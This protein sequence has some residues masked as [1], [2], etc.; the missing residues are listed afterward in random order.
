MEIIILKQISYTRGKEHIL[1][2][3]KQIGKKIES[4]ADLSFL[5]STRASTIISF[6]FINII[7][8]IHIEDN[9]TFIDIINL[10]RQLVGRSKNEFKKSERP[11]LIWNMINEIKPEEIGFDAIKLKEKIESAKAVF[12]GVVPNDFNA[13]TIYSFLLDCIEI[14]YVNLKKELSISNEKER[15]IQIEVKLNN[16]L[17]TAQKSGIN[18]D[19]QKVKQYIQE[20]NIDL[21]AVKNKLQLKFGVFSMYDYDNIRTKLITDFPWFKDIKLNSKEFWKAIKLQRNNSEFIELLYLERKHTKNKTILTR[22]GSLDIDNV[23]PMLDY[24]GTITGRI[25]ADSPSLQQLNKVYRDIIIPRAEMELVYIDYCQFEAGILAFEADEG[26]LIEMYNK[27]DI[28]TEISNKLGTKNVSRD[29]AKKLFFS[30]CYGMSKENILKYSG[31][32]LDLFFKE[33]PNLTNY[34]NAILKIFLDDGFVETTL[35]NR[36]YKSLNNVENKKEGWLISQKIQGKASLILKEVILQVYNKNKEIEF[37]LPMHDAILYQ[38]PQSKIDVLTKEI[39]DTFKSVLKRHCPSL[40]PKI[41][42]KPF[43]EA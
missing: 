31:K 9:I 17:F 28:Y 20:I 43:H 36:R 2:Y 24:M 38:V 26:K 39:E 11:W 33:F 1:F 37:L 21:Y 7:D 35:G 5:D 4:H 19:V 8:S 32:N 14:I 15:F 27:S 29:F 30:Y 18:I 41:S 40:D 42:I 10:K 6:D 13:S 3:T 16:V 25:L 22:I 12:L 23:N 34:E